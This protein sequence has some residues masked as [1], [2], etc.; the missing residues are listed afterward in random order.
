MELLQLLRLCDWTSIPF[1]EKGAVRI[2]RHADAR[3]DLESLLS[4]GYFDEYQRRH[5]RP[6]FGDASHMISFMAERG[7][8]SRLLGVYEIRGFR[9][10]DEAPFPEE[11]PYPDMGVGKYAYDIAKVPGFEELEGRLI[12]DWGAGTRSWCQHLLGKSKPIIELLPNG[13]SRDFPGFDR[14]LLSYEELEKIVR[15]PEPNRIWHTMLQSVAS[16]YLITVAK[17]GPSTLGRPMDLAACSHAGSTTCRPGTAITRSSRLCSSGT[18]NG[19]YRSATRSC[20]PC[21][22][23]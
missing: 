4:L 7:S 10:G 5:D 20:A 2:V 14:V 17:M 22:G 21:R 12:V 18:P 13:Y 23:P 11:Y 16:V 19:I 1:E 15:H 6:L 9:N 8:R 3:W